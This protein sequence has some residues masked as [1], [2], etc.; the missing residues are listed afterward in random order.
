MSFADVF[1][2]GYCEDTRVLLGPRVPRVPASLADPMALGAMMTGARI[3]ACFTPGRA[4]WRSAVL[5][6]LRRTA[7]PGATIHVHDGRPGPERA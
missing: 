1:V 7:V 2:L 4:G 3:V 6:A 5:E